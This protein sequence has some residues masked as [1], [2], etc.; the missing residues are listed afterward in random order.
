MILCAFFDCIHSGS[1]IW[2][3]KSSSVLARTLA[4]DAGQIGWQRR[5]TDRKNGRGEGTGPTIK[6]IKRKIPRCHTNN[7]TTTPSDTHAHTHKKPNAQGQF[8]FTAG[9]KENWL[10]QCV[11]SSGKK[12]DE[13]DPRATREGWAF[14]GN[15]D[16]TNVGIVMTITANTKWTWNVEKKNKK[17]NYS[18][19]LWSQAHVSRR[20]ILLSA[21]MAG[22]ARWCPSLTYG[23]QLRHW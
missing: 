23:F 22:G 8:K 15:L 6:R 7:Y 13:N 19:T 4:T 20:A 16:E 5:A 21:D 11:Q 18:G 10:A 3:F 17:K 1:Y 2:C 9:F 14:K 12:T